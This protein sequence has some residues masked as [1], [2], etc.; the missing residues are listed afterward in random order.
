M[1]VSAFPILLVVGGIFVALVVGILLWVVMD[2]RR[3]RGE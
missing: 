3:G 1:A 2:N